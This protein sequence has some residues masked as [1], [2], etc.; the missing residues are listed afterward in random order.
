MHEIDGNPTPQRPARLRVR[1]NQIDHTLIP[2]GSLDNSSLPQVPVLRIFGS[3]STSQTAC[4]HIHQVYP[5]FFVEYNGNLNQ[6]HGTESHS[7]P[8]HTLGLK[9]CQ[10]TVIYLSFYAP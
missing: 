2:P 9:S 5:Y 7:I 4:V 3:S 1:I 8:L 6:R 10:S